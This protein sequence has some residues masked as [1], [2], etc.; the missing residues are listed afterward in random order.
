M[1]QKQKLRERLVLLEGNHDRALLEFLRGGELAPLLAIGGAPTVLSYIGRPTG[2][3]TEKF[4]DS[5][6]SSHRELLESLQSVWTDGD[7]IVIHK[8]PATLTRTLARASLFWVT[9]SRTH[10]NPQSTNRA[11]ADGH[12]LWFVA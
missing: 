5:V 6:P 11:R 12:G 8:W 7:V 9:T 4:R 1:E 10:M 2:A 3:V